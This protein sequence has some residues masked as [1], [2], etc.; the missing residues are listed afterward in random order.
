V[1]VTREAQLVENL[2]LLALAG[3]AGTLARY[4]T[5]LAVAAVFG[6]RFPWATLVVNILGSFLFGCV[7]AL[8]TTGAIPRVSDQTRL[9]L[10]T[11]FMGSFTTFS[12]FAFETESLL[13]GASPALGVA[14]L[15]AQNLLGIAAVAAGFALC[16]SA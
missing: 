11:G 8:A 2:L 15:F 12:T 6:D 14:N 10:L 13:R 4:G 1:S 7:I 5:G 9:I 16:R 3:A